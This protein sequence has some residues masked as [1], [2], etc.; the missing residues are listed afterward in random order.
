MQA[1]YA[2]FKYEGAAYQAYKQQAGATSA[3]Y[4]F[5]NT[6]TGI[7]FYTIKR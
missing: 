1:N 7:H 2:D 4:R 3:V 6:V 5:Y